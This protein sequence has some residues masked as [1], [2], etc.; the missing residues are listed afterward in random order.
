ML[1]D[2]AHYFFRSDYFFNLISTPLISISTS[3]Y[4]TGIKQYIY[5]YYI[6]T[7]THIEDIATLFIIILIIFDDN[8]VRLYDNFEIYPKIM[9]AHRLLWL[10]VIYYLFTHRYFQI[11]QQPPN[12][13]AMHPKHFSRNDKKIWKNFS[14]RHATPV[15]FVKFQDTK[16]R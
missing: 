8:I 10:F 1:C 9:E 6:C 13:L 11:L 4:Q 7:S 3:L 16:K 15:Q 5:T 2:R 14:K 12:Y